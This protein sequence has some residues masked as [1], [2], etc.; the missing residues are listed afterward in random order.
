MIDTNILLRIA[1]KT[2]PMNEVAVQSVKVLFERGDALFITSQNLIEFW[3]VATRPIEVNG[4]GLSVA[5]ALEE[6]EEIKN[7]FT[8]LLDTENI[9]LIWEDLIARYQVSGKPAHDTRL[10]AAMIAHGLTDLLTFNTDDFKRLLEINAIAPN[11]L[12]T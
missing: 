12:Y 4:L 11:H 1:Q 8:L 2:H 9:F 3:V 5:R 10:V 6:L 7:T